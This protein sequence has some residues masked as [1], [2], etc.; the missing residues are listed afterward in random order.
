MI[1]NDTSTQCIHQNPGGVDLIN[2]RQSY[3]LRHLEI[4]IPHSLREQ[5]DTIQLQK[6]KALFISKP[7]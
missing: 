7:F 3:T 1:A 6:L 5:C 4:S 2:Y